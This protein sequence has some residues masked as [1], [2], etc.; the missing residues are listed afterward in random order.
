MHRSP[1]TTLARRAEQPW[2]QGERGAS[3]AYLKR[4]HLLFLCSPPLRKHTAASRGFELS[5]P[6]FSPLPR[7][8]AQMPPA[9]SDSASHLC[10]N[11]R[12]Y[13]FHRI[14]WRPGVWA[15]PPP[16]VRPASWEL[17]ATW[18]IFG[19]RLLTLLL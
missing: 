13:A 1:F 18:F 11:G 16:E 17:K 12:A 4:G 19:I 15:K 8:I 2:F 14:L 5:F 10:R 9:G 6:A 7:A 3:Q